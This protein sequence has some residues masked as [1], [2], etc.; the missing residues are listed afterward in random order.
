MAMLTLA[1]ALD[2][3]FTIKRDH[4]YVLHH[5]N[6][7]HIQTLLDETQWTNQICWDDNKSMLN[8]PGLKLKHEHDVMTYLMKISAQIQAT[9]VLLD[10]LYVD[11]NEIEA[12]DK[13]YDEFYNNN[14]YGT[15]EG[16][17]E[18]QMDLIQQCKT[19]VSNEGYATHK[20][21]QVGFFDNGAGVTAS[22]T[23]VRFYEGLTAIAY[24]LDT[25]DRNYNA[26]KDSKV[27][28][29]EQTFAGAAHLT[30]K[31]MDTSSANG[32]AFPVANCKDLAGKS[33]DINKFNASHKEALQQVAYKNAEEYVRLTNG[34]FSMRSALNSQVW[35]LPTQPK[36]EYQP[37]ISVAIEGLLNQGIKDKTSAMA[38]AVERI[39]AFID[40]HF[41]RAAKCRFS[42]DMNFCSVRNERCVRHEQYESKTNAGIMPMPVPKG[43]N[44]NLK[45]FE[46]ENVTQNRVESMEDINNF[47]K[48]IPTIIISAGI[49]SN[50]HHWYV[51]CWNLINN[52]QSA[53]PKWPSIKWPNDISLQIIEW[54][55][56]VGFDI[57]QIER[58]IVHLLHL[59]S[60]II[61]L[62]KEHKETLKIILEE[63]TD[64][65]VEYAE[66]ILDDDEEEEVIT[67]WYKKIANE[68][69]LSEKTVKLCAQ[70]IALSVSNEEA[71]S[72]LDYDAPDIEENEESEPRKYCVC[73]KP[74]DCNAI[75]IDCSTCGEDYHIEC[76]NMTL[77]EYQFE[78][79]KEIHDWRCKLKPQCL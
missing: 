13:I 14:L 1:F 57:E 17:H 49:N 77:D 34:Y 61:K 71:E 63:H 19:V 65:I 72:A 74:Y 22:E 27:Q 58:Q 42:G 69:N 9:N 7:H 52:L 41:I 75:M 79:Y 39:F 2:N 46:Y 4:S 32:V 26:A 33:V 66:I 60:Y 15:L 10:L 59:K 45:R 48:W 11:T 21:N 43:Y 25:T 68:I 50:I 3:L 62:K 6:L 78:L 24:D 53:E 44:E 8:N 37:L 31:N 70:E 16:W 67:A 36:D 76:V 30:T 38:L 29:H 51:S 73:N 23:K 64:F 35:P 40:I 5:Q 47:D 28:F 55:N 20:K 12:V 18:S 54:R 56:T